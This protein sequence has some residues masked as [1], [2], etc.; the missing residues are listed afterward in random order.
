MDEKDP[1]SFDINIPLILDN[2]IDSNLDIPLILD[3]EIHP[4]RNIK[5]NILKINNLIKSKYLSAEKLS[6][7]KKPTPTDSEF[8]S[9]RNKIKEI[10]VST[11]KE[12]LLINTNIENQEINLNLLNT[13]KKLSNQNKIQS[14]IIDNQRQLIMNLKVN[15][16][17]LNS[18]LN[19]TKK[20]LEENINSNKYLTNINIE[21]E[22]SISKL[23][24]KKDET[25]LTNKQINELNDKIKFYQEENIRLS[26]ELNTIQNKYKTIKH[27]FEDVELQKNKIYTQIQQLNNSLTKNN[28]VGTPFIKETI[29]DDSINSKILND[30]SSI[31]YQE[32]KKKSE[33]NIDL[34]EDINDIFK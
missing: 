19:N 23:V 14:D 1:D 7:S 3:N 4:G 18:N 15:N 17:D 27:N 32:D 33:L 28:I 22:N 24:N 26:S 31:N 9:I 21:L 12:I 13:E 34:D 30:I 29:K 2:E 20:K 16:E 10:N 8:F 25:L 6:L 5:N 11:K